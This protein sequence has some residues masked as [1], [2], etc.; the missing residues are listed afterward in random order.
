VTAPA[1]PTWRRCRTCRGWLG[2]RWAT[3]AD[4]TTTEGRLSGWLGR[5]A[6]RP[7][8]RH[9]APGFPG[10]LLDRTGL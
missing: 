1:T 3:A 8:H 4:E 9:R 10:W 5:S 7:V 6:A 2:A